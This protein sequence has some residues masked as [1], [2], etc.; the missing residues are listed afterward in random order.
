MCCFQLNKLIWK[1]GVFQYKFAK[2]LAREKHPGGL[3]TYSVF[4]TRRI[5][6]FTPN[7][8][9]YFANSRKYVRTTIARNVIRRITG[10]GVLVVEGSE[11]RRQR[12]ILN[13]AFSSQHIKHLTHTFWAKACELR[14]LWDQEAV[15][16]D[17]KSGYNVVEALQ[18]TTLDI[19]GLAGF[20]P[21]G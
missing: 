9:N 18:R 3:Y 2:T 21:C 4:G 19:I 16:A 7:A 20:M 6:P 10:E 1:I 5:I 17:P 14:D 11:H 15:A 12:R 8:I 13:P